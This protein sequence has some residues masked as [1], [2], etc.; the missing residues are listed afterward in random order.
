MEVTRPTPIVEVDEPP[1]SS[2]NHLLASLG[3]C[4][5][6][7]KVRAA[8]TQKHVTTVR[9]RKRRASD[10]DVRKSIQDVQTHILPVRCKCTEN[11]LL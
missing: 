3:V 4:L 10:I 2:I 5:M 6:S 11:S 8:V 7:G 9:R 1:T